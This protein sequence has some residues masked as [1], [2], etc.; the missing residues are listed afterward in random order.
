MSGAI[1]AAA[2]A[3]GARVVDSSERADAV[4]YA[5]EDPVNA[6]GVARSVTGAGTPIVL[7]DALVLAGVADRLD[8]AARRRTVLVSSAPAPGAA[9]VRALA[10]AFRTAFGR[11][12]GPYAVIGYQAMQAVIAALD[13]VGT[14]DRRRQAV[15]AAF[16]PP[17]QLGF[18]AYRADGR[19]L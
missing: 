16:T 19:P 10:P 11:D 14:R 17:P 9:P 1:V 3:A 6:A 12:P 2:R 4:I 18:G 7:G 8:A 13:R 5:G 15:T